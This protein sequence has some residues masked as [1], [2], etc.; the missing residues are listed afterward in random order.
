MT[1][2]NSECDAISPDYSIDF[3]LLA[4]NN[5]LRTLRLTSLSISVDS[6]GIIMYGVPQRPNEDFIVTE[7]HKLFR[8]LSLTDMKNIRHKQQIK[9]LSFG[10]DIRS[11]LKIMETQKNLLLFFPFEF[12]I[13]EDVEIKKFRLYKK[14]SEILKL[15]LS[16]G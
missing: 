10:G 9:E 1:E 8:P 4:T 12:L 15:E 5:H 13:D 16:Q 14:E 11:V 2:H 3:K 7:I 6:D